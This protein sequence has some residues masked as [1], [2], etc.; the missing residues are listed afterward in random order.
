MGREKGGSNWKR[1]KRKDQ[2]GVESRK[3]I[4]GAKAAVDSDKYQGDF[5]KIVEGKKTD[6]LNTVKEQS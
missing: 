6:G 3:N 2:T 4:L 1:Q 5:T